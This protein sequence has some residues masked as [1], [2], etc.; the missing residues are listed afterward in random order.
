MPRQKRLQDRGIYHLTTRGNRG[1]PIALDGGDHEEFLRRVARLAKE[2]GWIYLMY[3]LM[4]N[5]Y[6]LL[7]ETTAENLSEGMQQL[8]GGFAKWFNRKHELG[9]HLFE[10]RFSSVQ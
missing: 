5:H 1:Q 9:G 2:L 10:R 7:V 6:H 8:N 4:T 3:C